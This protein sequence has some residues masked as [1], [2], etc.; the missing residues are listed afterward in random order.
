MGPFQAP[1]KHNIGGIYVPVKDET[2]LAPMDPRR[3]VLRDHT[4]ASGA[5]LRRSAGIDEY[6]SSSIPL[7]LVGGQGSELS[8]RGVHY[9]SRQIVVFD[10]LRDVEVL[11]DDCGVILGNVMRDLVAVVEALVPDLAPCFA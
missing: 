6:H 2:A 1:L 11:E 3:E 9:C 8:P 10:H 4:M 5:F 7:R